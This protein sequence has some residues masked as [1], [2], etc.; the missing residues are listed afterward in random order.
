MSEERVVLTA[1]LRDELSAP[2]ASVSR[3]VRNTASDV[4]RASSDMSSSTRTSSTNIMTALGGTQRS[5]SGLSGAWS[6][7]SG[8]ART[9]W[10]GAKNAVM[11][12]AQGIK[13]ASRRAGEESGEELSRGFSGKLKG[14]IGGAVAALGVRQIAVGMSSAVAS[15]SEL[16]DS[17]AA[18]SVVF[19]DSMGKI[20]EQSKTADKALGLSQQAVINGANTFGTYGKAAGLG[21]D[22]LATFATDLTGLAGDMASFKGTSTEQALDAI[23]AGLRGEAEPLR[24]FGVMLDDVQM[25][26]EALRMGLVK[27]TKDALTPQQKVLVAQSLIFAQTKDAQGDFARTSESTANIAKTLSAATENLSAKLGGMLA[28]AFTAV[29]KKILHGVYAVSNFL[30]RVTAAQAVM[31]G[32][33]SNMDIAKALGLSPEAAQRFSDFIGPFRAFAAAYRDGTSDVTSSGIAGVFEQLGGIIGRLHAGWTIAREDVVAIGSDIDPLVGRVFNLKLGMTELLKNMSPAQWAGVAGGAA[34]LL[35]S[36]GKLGPMLSPLLG[37]FARLGPMVGGLGGALKFLLGPVGLIAG[38]FIFA[39]STSEPFREAINGL[40]STILQLAVGLGAQLLPLFG[41]LVTTLLPVITQLFSQLV[42]IFIQ[43][44]MAV[45]PIVATLA[46]QLLP[47]FMQ[48]II[49]VLPPLMGLLIGLAPIFMQLISAL[50]PLIPPVMEIV[51]LLLDMAIKVI[52]PLM[53]LLTMVAT[54]FSV[55]LGGAIGLLMPIVKFLIEAFVNLVTFL[56]GPLGAAIKWVGGLFEGIAKIIGDV[57]KSV[58]DFFSNPLGGLQDMLG[59]PKNS[60]GGTYSGGGVIGYA[61]GGSVLGGYA[62]G[63]DTIPALLSPGESVLVPELTAAIGPQRIMAA[64]HEASGGRPAGSGPAL[65]AGFSQD[66]G[67]APGG[68]SSSSVVVAEGAVQIT[69]VA[70]NDGLSPAQIAQVRQAVEQV[71]RDARKRGY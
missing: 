37:I 31:K 28:P 36:F 70:G 59:L 25:R 50:V 54:I 60:G 29:R 52:A 63:R 35:A 1:T 71:F 3:A 22:E 32:G 46:T 26:D 9:A 18:A 4:R 12:A 17:S 68:A 69:I 41:M 23:A 48:L 66:A 55:V 57:A 33:G 47:I 62:P 34:L 14:L 10:G 49:A 16:E 61:G 44:V 43:I 56:E 24:A 15:F 40:L 51:G 38:L 20:I 64:N 27:T 42:P 5:T 21:G 65:L 11:Q 45:L 58:G 6:R 7:L 67:G 30:D 8:T 53:P 2:L 39:Y 13:S 19:G